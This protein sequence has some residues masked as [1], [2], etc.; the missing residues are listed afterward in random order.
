SKRPW[1]SKKNDPRNSH[2]TSAAPPSATQ[3]RLSTA[4][5]STPAPEPVRTP[6]PTNPQ[7]VARRAGANRTSSG[8]ASRAAASQRNV[9]E[10]GGAATDELAAPDNDNRALGESGE[11]RS[12]CTSPKSDTRGAGFGKSPTTVPP[13]TPTAT[14]VRAVGAAPARAP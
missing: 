8:H 11:L 12:R 1:A 14:N 13:S 9:A 4:G 5:A 10:P 3:R 7:G 2:F 6:S